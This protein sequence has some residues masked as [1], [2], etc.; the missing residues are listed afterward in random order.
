MP[1]ISS[2]PIRSTT[3]EADVVALI[4]EHHADPARFVALDVASE[5][6]QHNA[7][8]DKSYVMPVAP[9]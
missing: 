5:R 2:S 3:P 1:G 9:P 6:Q 7:A 8:R 4:V